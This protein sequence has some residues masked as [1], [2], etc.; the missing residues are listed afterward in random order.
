MRLET[1]K[2]RPAARKVE[3]VILFAVGP[4]RFAIAAGAV[5]EIRNLDGL[6]PHSRGYLSRFEKVRY[7][8]VRE[9]KDPG[10]TYFVVDGALQFGL[11]P[12]P[13]GRVLV[14]RG[15]GAAL[16]VDRIDRMAQISSIVELPRAFRGPERTWY[17]G[18]AIL[19]GRV[20]PVLQ[21]AAILNKGE[22]AVLLAEAL[23]PST[24][25]TAASA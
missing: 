21:P 18:L 12:A 19:D 2:R 25:P 9:H 24:P 23:T 15:P 1:R 11:P 8:L 22:V 14:L 4:A 6:T 10:K 17:R 16:L 3:D 5:D 7:R 20:V 13:G